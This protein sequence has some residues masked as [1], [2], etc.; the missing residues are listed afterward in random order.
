MSNAAGAVREPEEGLPRPSASRA[1]PARGDADAL[2]VGGAFV[3][4]GLAVAAAHRLVD[5]R[6]HLR[7]GLAGSALVR[8]GGAGGVGAVEAGGAL[9][10]GDAAAG[11]AFGLSR[12]GTAYSGPYNMAGEPISKGGYT[13]LALI[14][15]GMAYRGATAATVRV[16]IDG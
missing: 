14:I 12:G 2:G 15:G 7:R 8:V 16:K 9:Q 11:P 5:V 13:V 1:L 10:G 4:V 6:A 3:G